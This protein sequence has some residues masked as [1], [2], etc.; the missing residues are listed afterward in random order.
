MTSNKGSGPNPTNEPMGLNAPETTQ[1]TSGLELLP[2]ELQRAILERVPRRDVLNAA[3]V[4]AMSYAARLILYTTVSLRLAQHESFIEDINR[5][6]SAGRQNMALV[7]NL[8]I[9]N[10]KKRRA[11][12]SGHPYRFYR[13]GEWRRRNLFTQNS[14]HFN[15]TMRGLF[16]SISN[17]RTV[18]WFHL[19]KMNYETFASLFAMHVD[20]LMGIETYALTGDEVPILPGSHSLDRF[21]RLRIALY[22]PQASGWDNTLNP[23]MITLL[24]CLT[25]RL[26]HLVLGDEG[27][28]ISVDRNTAIAPSPP[29]SQASI[30]HVL[31]PLARMPAV[32]DNFSKLDIIGMD[33]TSPPNQLAPLLPVFD[34][35]NLNRL[36]L[37]SCVGTEGFLKALSRP[38]PQMMFPYVASRMRLKEFCIRYEGPTLELKVALQQFLTSFTGLE[39]LSV[40]LDDEPER[41]MMDYTGIILA[42]GPTLKVL[43]WDIRK[44]N[45]HQRPFC[46]ENPVRGRPAFLELLSETCP[47]LEEL[48]VVLNMRLLYQRGQDIDRISSHRPFAMVRL[49]RLKTLHCREFFIQKGR[50]LSTARVLNATKAIATSFL[51]RAYYSHNGSSPL[52]LLAVGPLNFHDR[53]IQNHFSQDYTATPG[54]GPVFYDISTCPDNLMGLAHRLNPLLRVRQPDLNIE[55][56]DVEMIRQD[57]KHTRVFDS[58]WV[59]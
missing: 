42:H 52:E 43:V 6:V 47:N 1:V 38:E 55:L 58:Y 45:R 54:A 15:E 59:R 22:A 34:L 14:N 7:Q 41:E 2:V 57:Y 35:Y 26:N 17:L 33:I 4:K 21:P 20:T 46:L 39:L 13:N 29:R 11:V 9:L 31:L 8:S 12:G 27:L 50:L 30:Y 44:C 48:G 28:V 40:L 51:D 18:R 16:A 24:A 19:F 36:S 56:D 32:F 5:F 10:W 49:P 25:R 53:W 37:V 3:R 23:S